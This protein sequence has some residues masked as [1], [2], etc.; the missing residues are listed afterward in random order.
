MLTILTV[1][2]PVSQMV[3]GFADFIKLVGVTAHLLEA[4]DVTRTVA[5][6]ACLF[7]KVKHLVLLFHCEVALVLN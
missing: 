7:Q 4:A 2:S 5:F 6:P 1:F 3:A